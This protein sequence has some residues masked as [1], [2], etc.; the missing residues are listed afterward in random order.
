MIVVTN[1]MG[2]ATEVSNRIMFMEKGH[3]VEEGPPRQ[4]FYNAQNARTKEFL[5]KITELYGEEQE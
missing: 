4:L 5:G 2:L 3:I 1:E